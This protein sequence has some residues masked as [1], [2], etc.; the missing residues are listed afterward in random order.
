M[1]SNRVERGLRKGCSLS[2]HIQRTALVFYTHVINDCTPLPIAKQALQASDALL[3][4]LL[5]LQE[6]VNPESHIR[7]LSRGRF[8]LHRGPAVV[9]R[10][11]LD[12]LSELQV[13]QRR[14]LGERKTPAIVGQKLNIIL[15]LRTTPRPWPSPDSP[16]L[17]LVC[18]LWRERYASAE[19]DVHQD[20]GYSANT[21]GAPWLAP[22]KEAMHD[23]CSPSHHCTHLASKQHG[24][25]RG[26][27]THHRTVD[28][29]DVDA[30]ASS[31]ADRRSEQPSRQ[32]PC[33][34]NNASVSRLHDCI[35]EAVRFMHIRNAAAA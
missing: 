5:T 23:T 13:V 32:P 18:R 30:S 27:V 28:V 7:H 16:N 29:L 31:G 9:V 20:Q 25:C 4:Q 24:D 22:K 17:L 2:L 12:K 1:R 34:P 10:G 26:A 19:R 6:D 8:F 33:R 21:C 15:E 14:L 3:I 35:H 11:R